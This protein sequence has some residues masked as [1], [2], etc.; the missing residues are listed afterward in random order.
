MMLPTWMHLLLPVAESRPCAP[1]RSEIGMSLF[2]RKKKGK[3]GV[4]K[5]LAPWY[6]LFYIDGQ[7]F[8]G[9][10]ETTNEREAIK[11]EA[12]KRVAAENGEK[13]AKKKIVAV[14]DLIIGFQDWVKTI[15][16]APKTIADYNYGCR[17]ILAT[18]LAGMRAD[19]VTDD[20][21]SATKFHESPYSTNS[22][23]RTLRRAYRRAFK[24]KE[25]REMP[26][27]TLVNAPRRERMVSDVDEARLLKAIEY[28]ASNRR[29]KNRPASPLDDVLILMLD[30][31][32]RDGEVVRMELQNINRI[33]GH[34]FN[35][36]GKTKRARRRVPLSKRV[37]ARL[38]ARCGELRE[39]W[40]FPSRKSRSGHIE[41]RGL[42]KEFRIIARALGIPEDL[43]LYCSRHTFGTVAMDETGNPYAVMQAM[44]HEDL[45]TTMGYM[46]NDVMQL[47]A[48][49]DKRNDSKL[50]Q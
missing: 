43:K 44:G 41:L 5:E 39:G 20:D 12:R 46:H 13:I 34:Y 38:E 15:N 23:L 49:I 35:P 45:D 19:R 16:K 22:A 28:R 27:I 47:K 3:D 40:V 30:S 8:M 48:V 37:L 7:R 26:E 21:I 14:R 42:Q 18:P 10:T 25:L 24:K 32:M 50:V 29:Y 1:A 2:K 17:L 36:K 9:S 33:E 31:G 4:T 6:Y 11:V